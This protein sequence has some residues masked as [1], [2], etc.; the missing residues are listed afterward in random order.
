M[1]QFIDNILVSDKTRA[2]PIMTHPGIE[3]LG[4]TVKDAVTNG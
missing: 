2:F 4:Y 1:K 3:A